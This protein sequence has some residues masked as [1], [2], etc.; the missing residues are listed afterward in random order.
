MSWSSRGGELCGA[1]EAEEVFPSGCR[2]VDGKQLGALS[3][4]PGDRHPLWRGAGLLKG[5]LQQLQ[6]L[7][8]AVVD[9][10]Q[11]EVVRIAAADALRVLA[12]LLQSLRL[13]G[14]RQCSG[15]ELHST[16]QQGNTLP[17]SK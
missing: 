1:G 15:E 11:V 2:M 8:H 9:Q 16:P 13:Q 10:G 4:D 5:F 7:F 17:T 12:Q 3:V 6:A 14:T